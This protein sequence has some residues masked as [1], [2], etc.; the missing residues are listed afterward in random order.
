MPDQFEFFQ[1]LGHA[2]M[3]V[4]AQAATDMK[5]ASEEKPQLRI[6]AIRASNFKGLKAI[7]ITPEDDMIELNGAN[8]AGKSSVIDVIWFAL[9]GMI[10]APPEPIRKGEELA[11]VEMT[12]GRRDGDRR[13]MYFITRKLTRKGD[14]EVTH[15]IKMETGDGARVSSPQE[16]LNTLFSNIS[17][18]PMLF[19]RSNKREQFEMLRALVPG[20]DFDA[21]EKANKAD[22]DKRTGINS[23]AASARAQ[24]GPVSA[25]AGAP[26]Q[27]INENALIEQLQSSVNHNA[28]VDRQKRSREHEIAQRDYLKGEIDKCGQ[29][30][31]RLQAAIVEEQ[32]REANLKSVL[33]QADEKISAFE[34]LQAEIDA[35]DISAKLADAKRLNQAYDARARHQALIFDAEVLEHE[36][37]KL[38]AAMK[39]RTEETQKAIAAAN[40]PVEGLSFGDGEILLDRLPF[41]QAST[42][43][44]IRTSVAIAV[45]RNPQLKLAFVRDG[46]LLDRK[47]MGLLAEYANEWGCQVITERPEAATAS[48]I[49]IEDGY[50]RQ[51]AIAAE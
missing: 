49:L 36:S 13:E 18:D 27:R 35:S 43:K 34:P 25:F 2:A 32:E 33:V 3:N 29:E 45:S 17:F 15:S 26:A 38:T 48:S 50:S 44:Q 11:K 37:S 20:V 41:E 42:A 19:A 46:G 4:V 7:Y 28:G 30:I 9:K 12:L 31:K 8:G 6:M 14:R 51:H 22:Y 16:V 39:Q 40:L 1:P 21:V 24:A 47:S 5:A 23:Q 10:V